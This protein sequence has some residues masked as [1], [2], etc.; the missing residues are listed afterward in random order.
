M[1]DRFT[2]L[3]YYLVSLML[4]AELREGGV[5]FEE[6]IA[7]LTDWIVVPRGY[8]ATGLT[9]D[10]AH[11]ESIDTLLVEISIGQHVPL[12]HAAGV[13]PAVAIDE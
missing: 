3:P 11:Q 9:A 4:V 8:A 10:I 2:S 12:A 13:G 7:H 5:L 1:R 6:V